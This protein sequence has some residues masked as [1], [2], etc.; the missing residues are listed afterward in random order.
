MATRP[1]VDHRRLVFP[2]DFRALFLGVLLGPRSVSSS[3]FCTA[4]DD[5]AEAR[6][7][8]FCNGDPPRR[9]F[10]LIAHSRSI[11]SMTAALDHKAKSIL[12]CPGRF[13]PGSNAEYSLLAW[14]SSCGRFSSAFHAGLS[15]G[16]PCPDLHNAWRS[17][18][19]LCNSS[20]R[21]AIRSRFT[22]RFEARI[23]WCLRSCC[24]AELNLRASTSTI[25]IWTPAPIQNHDIYEPTLILGDSYQSDRNFSPQTA[26]VIV[27]GSRGRSIRLIR[28]G[29]RS[30]HTWIYLDRIR[31][32]R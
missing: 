32:S 22:P 29:I 3:R 23:T 14:R 18:E 30:V 20:Q 5:C 31:G 4:I 24:A 25:L 12:D 16:Y 21:S 19:R 26:S 7:M 1:G 8:G 13:S 11:K 28:G 10:S 2:L 6:R 15:Q 9:T 17:G 27:S